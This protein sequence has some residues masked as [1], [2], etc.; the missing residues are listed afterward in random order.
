MYFFLLS[1]VNKCFKFTN[2]LFIII[3]SQIYDSL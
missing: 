3:Y 2:I 1:N